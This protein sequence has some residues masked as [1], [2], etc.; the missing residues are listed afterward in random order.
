MFRKHKIVRNRS[1]PSCPSLSLNESSQKR[2]PQ[3]C[4]RSSK[5]KFRNTQSL[6]THSSTQLRWCEIDQIHLSQLGGV[7]RTPNNTHRCN[8]ILAPI[9][10]RVGEG[11]RVYHSLSLFDESFTSQTFRRKCRI[12]TMRKRRSEIGI[13]LGKGKKNGFGDP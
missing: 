6:P 3:L 10:R 7:D 12:S 1:L 5:H 4:S 2:T 9:W 13:A 11:S 8:L